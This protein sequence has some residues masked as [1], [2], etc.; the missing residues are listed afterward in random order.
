L[1]D[2]VQRQR[3][4]ERL[5]Q[6]TQWTVEN[7]ALHSVEYCQAQLETATSYGRKIEAV[8]HEVTVK[9]C[10]TKR[11]IEDSESTVKTIKN[12][13]VTA[14]TA[15]RRAEASNA[16]PVVVNGF[17]L[18]KVKAQEKIVDATQRIEPLQGRIVSMRKRETG[19]LRQNGALRL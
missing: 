14:K 13:L 6:N 19:E 2:I 4:Q 8:L 7:Q 1:P 15:Y 11:S 17:S 9:E 10:S 18:S 12:F 3:D 16:W 5:R